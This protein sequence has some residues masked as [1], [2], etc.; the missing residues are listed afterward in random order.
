MSEKYTFTV[1]KYSTES[2]KDYLYGNIVV[3]V[4]S[5][6]F[7]NNFY[8]IVSF[9]S[10]ENVVVD[11]IKII[12]EG[13]FANYRDYDVNHRIKSER[14]S[15]LQGYFGFKTFDNTEN[16][17]FNLKHFLN[18]NNIDESFCIKWDH[19]T[20]QLKKWLKDL[21]VPHLRKEL[22]NHK[23]IHKL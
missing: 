22:E 6:E 8:L 16:A 2:S 4:K 1:S 3:L 18:G 15:Y 5:N 20:I 19:F 13:I 9:D 14:I 10:E 23:A 21:F 7:T 11:S 17:I 12:P